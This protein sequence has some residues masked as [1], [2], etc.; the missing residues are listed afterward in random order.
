MRRGRWGLL[1][2]AAAASPPGCS[3][4]L[5]SGDPE[6]AAA[7]VSVAAVRSDMEFA[8]P[9]TGY[10]EA[11]QA[12]PIAVPQVPTGALKV[13]QVVDEGSIVEKGD[14]VVVFDDTQLTIELD[15]HKA[16]FLSTNRRLNRNDLQS[17]IESG[18]IEVMKEVAEMERDNVE[19]FAIADESIYSRLEILE[20]GVRKDE[21]EGTIVFADISLLLRGQYYDIEERILRVERG[22]V[23]GNIDRLGT[24]LGNLVLK[25]PLGGL[26]IYKK[27]WRG[28]SVQVGDTLWPGNVIL[29]IV[30]PA[31]TLL[32]AFALEKDAAGIEEGAAATVR[33]DARPERVFSGRVKSVAEISRPIE[34]NSPVKYTE[35]RI[36]IEGGDPALLKPGM[37]GEAWISIGRV[38][39]AIV[40]P[41]SALRTD[42]EAH[43]VLVEGPRGSE[44]RPV[45]PGVGDQVRVSIA[46]GIQEGERVILGGGEA[47]SA[48]TAPPEGGAAPAGARPSR[49]AGG[50]RASAA[51]P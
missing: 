25:A 45:V 36:A 10:L 37:K 30:D 48:P 13:K 17:D 27:N 12:S 15:N 23:Q 47:P 29:S 44:R 21:A 32:S 42:G 9:A 40:V 33:V 6:E 1:L 4:L 14:V 11:I 3:G 46:E 26:V 7:V 35:V 22:Q 51:V 41:R 43:Y 24:S 16:S 31:S 8:V 20:Q 5:G 28:G 39:S 2:L 50:I 49:G 18:S 38:A 34:R 19:A